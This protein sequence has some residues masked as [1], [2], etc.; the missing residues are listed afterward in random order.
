MLFRVYTYSQLQNTFFQCQTRKI[1]VRWQQNPNFSQKKQQ[2]KK[3]PVDDGSATDSVERKKN[4][5]EKNA[6]NENSNFV[7][8]EQREEKKTLYR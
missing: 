6:K 4:I 7:R 1:T 3:N 8:F 5:F 2:L